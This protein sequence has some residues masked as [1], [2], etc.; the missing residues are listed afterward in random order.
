MNAPLSSQEV[1]A[2][3]AAGPRYFPHSLDIAARRVLMLDLPAD[4]Y[5]AES[6]LDDR[7]FQAG[8]RGG[9]LGEDDFLAMAGQ[10]PAPTD[11]PGFIFHVGHCGSTLVSRLLAA[12]GG[13]PV[14]EPVPLRVLADA[15]CEA[16][17]P[18]DPLG[19]DRFRALIDAFG[20]SWA[21]RPD[22]MS[23]AIVKATSL[24]SGLAPDL[25]AAAPGSKVLALRIPLAAWLAALLAPETPSADL[26]RGARVRLSRLTALCGGDPG[27]RLHAL[28]PGELAA[29]SWLTEAATLAG[30]HRAEPDRVMA[31]DFEDFL[32]QPAGRLHDMARHFGLALSRE[33]AG[34]AIASPVMSRYSKAPDQGFTAHDRAAMQAESAARNAGEI[35]KGLTLVEG[36][37]GRYEGLTG[38]SDWL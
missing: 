37:V 21:R 1:A 8:P 32:K 19:D 14:R 29:V 10:L 4:T 38:V 11:A 17:K 30:L 35:A 7:L 34:A 16:G 12:G 18:W 13:F 23:R 33:D 36:L 31:L 26:M 22:G 15:R 5:L 9:W 20:R 6:F 25:M 3:F 27:V 24:S 28:S 2:G